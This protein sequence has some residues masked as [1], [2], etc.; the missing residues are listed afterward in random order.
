VQGVPSIDP[1]EAKL[2]DVWKNLPAYPMGIGDTLT[3]SETLRG[4]ANP[5]PDQLSLNRTLWLDFDGA[6]YS[7]SDRI[8]GTLHREPRLM[9]APPTVLGRLSIAGRDQFITH[10]DDA[11]PVGVELRQ[12]ELSVTADSR[13]TGSSGSI[14]AVGWVH[15]FH[16]VEA[17]LHL[18]PGWKLFYASGADD[19]SGT[20]VGG[21][22]LFDFFL[23]LVLA[24]ATG[25]LFGLGWGAVALAT[26]IVTFPEADAPHYTWVFVLV[27]EALV[28]VLPAG[29][30][31]RFF[32][33]VRLAALA[34]VALVAVP[35]LIQD[36]REGIYP[37]L[38]NESAAVAV[39]HAD[40]RGILG[41]IPELRV[42]GAAADG[43]GVAKAPAPTEP[44]MVAAAANRRGAVGAAA[45]SSAALASTHGSQRNDDKTTVY[46]P[47]TIVQTGPGLPL[48]RW[49][50][51]DLRW[52]GPVASTQ[53]LHLYLLSP[54]ENLLLAFVRAGLLV[55]LFLGLTPWTR[56][57]LLRGPHGWTPA[58]AALAIGCAV[59]A[60]P[61]SARADLP[62]TAT[63]QELA[64][65]LTRA[66]DCSPQCASEQRMQ[67]DVRDIGLRALLE[68]DASAATAV[69]LPGGADWSP[70]HVVL[71]G[72]PAKGLL[73]TD[74]GIL[75]IELAPGNHR[76]AVD[77]PI[78]DRD[79][80]PL[81]LHMKAHHVD[82]VTSADWTVTGVHEDGSADDDLEL[83]RVRAHSVADAG[84][85][86]ESAAL[87]PFVRVERTVHV[88][89]DWQIDNRVVRVTPLGSAIAVGIPLLPGESVTTPDVRV[90]AGKAEIHVGPQAQEVAWRSVLDKKSPL[91]LVAPKS[92]AWTEVWRIDVEPIWHASFTGIPQIH[93]ASA[94]GTQVPEFRPWPGEQLT[95]DLVRPAGVA[96]QTLTIDDSTTDFQPGL[97]ATD[98]TLTIHLRSSRGGEH[99]ITIPPD[100][101]IESLAIDGA[102]QPVRQDGRR[103]T[104]PVVP[105][106]RTIALT[107]REPPGIEALFVAPTID[108]GAPS[109][110]ATVT[111][112]VPGG[113][114]LL[115]A[116]GPRVGPAVLFWSLLLVLLLASFGLGYNH[117]TPLGRWQWFLLSIGLSQVSVGAGAVFVGWLL[118]LG[119]RARVDDV[120]L[121]R[122]WFN[123]RQAALAAWT[124]IA[125]G[126]LAVSL[127]QGLLGMPEMQ[128]SGNGSSSSMLR[129]FADRSS[130]VLPSPWIVSVPI[131]VYRGAML[132]WA[133]W[134]A[135]AL[136]GW[137]TWG[138]R[139][140]VSGPS[141]GWR[142]KA[143]RAA[144]A[145]VAADGARPLG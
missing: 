125:L 32:Q 131:L 34:I 93:T 49:T 108:L 68:V 102:A 38:A 79:S 27:A 36:V 99:T 61:R 98:V 145:I 109:V 92:L 65:R 57:R 73:R 29:G 139:A 143:P 1:Q 12:G 72:R 89:L 9:M 56:R 2:P 26:M 52:S 74:D 19:V 122:R 90:E 140:F 5:P 104:F 35:F 123:L 112:A 78:P 51:F 53:T 70:A 41:T 8:T 144:P 83:T 43:D 17:R 107:W 85:S 91:K 87:P 75:W 117:W 100:A 62:D 25:R 6:G 48:W 24:I 4:D 71:D 110:N 66:P 23:A 16:Q 39:S 118:A 126:I 76:I 105:G 64:T 97:R 11:S 96:G 40:E 55:A 59:I 33:G 37:A 50:A 63:L 82:V 133:L 67:L 142:R 119:W 134:I 114:W 141:G 18:P 54:H 116:G 130:G 14:P 28:R 7:I 132:A 127:Y 120:A 103:V 95:V 42:T 45:P 3:L 136:L 30:V 138:W 15:D 135:L 81:S 69:P 21:W 80:V 128:V 58:V 44:S 77:G 106:A 88:G 101:Q 86:P 111:M 31:R 84:S 20:W 13:Y 124:C 121:G 137:L 94:A 22:S 46:D 129:W 115:F 60:V 47:A 10:L 113:R